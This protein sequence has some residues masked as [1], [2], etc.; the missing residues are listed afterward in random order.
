[1][2]D[3]TS[4]VAAVCLGDRDFDHPARF[5]QLGRNLADRAGQ[6]LHGARHGIG[7]AVGLIGRGGP[8][9]RRRLQRFGRGGDLADHGLD[10]AFETLGQ[11]GI[12]HL[13][14]GQISGELTAL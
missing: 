10:T 12:L 6:L 13:A 3:D 5:G 4:R 8:R 9:L 7:L 11:R 2:L 1:M 14:L